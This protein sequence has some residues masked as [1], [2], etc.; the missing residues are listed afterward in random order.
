LTA[1][2]SVSARSTLE[3]SQA[4][5]APAG[6]TDLETGLVPR[7]QFEAE[8]S[9]QRPVRFQKPRAEV[10]GV[11]AGFDCQLQEAPDLLDLE[12]FKRALSMHDSVSTEL[13]LCR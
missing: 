6:A 7:P 1:S 5:R 4:D 3:M 2:A 13:E 12:R 9:S 8:L 11:Q 10:I